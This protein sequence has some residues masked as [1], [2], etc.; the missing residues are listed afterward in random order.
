MS[1]PYWYKQ[2]GGFVFNGH[3]ISREEIKTINA[4]LDG[5]LERPV[6]RL[7]LVSKAIMDSV[8]PV[9][10]IPA[11][12]ETHRMEHIRETRLNLLHELGQH[13]IEG[14]QAQAS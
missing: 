8:L 4:Q 12:V 2:H 11:E 9:G 13:M 14:Q 1:T 10:W 7:S 5:Y 3:R 6:K